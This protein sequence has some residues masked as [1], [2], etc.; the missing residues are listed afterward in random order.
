MPAGGV[1]VTPVE[2]AW[3]RVDTE[4]GGRVQVVEVGA[5]R[6]G[7]GVH[8]IRNILASQN[9]GKREIPRSRA[10]V[11]DVL[12]SRVDAGARASPPDETSIKGNGFT[13]EALAEE[14]I[15]IS[16]GWAR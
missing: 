16:V 11:V 3:T 7:S 13:I 14:A 2:I 15:V 9:V 5:P 1:A 10:L 4:E 8:W 6:I 12:A